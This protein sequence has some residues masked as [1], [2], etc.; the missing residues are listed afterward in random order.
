M[1]I[2]IENSKEFFETIA[3]VILEYYIEEYKYFTSPEYF[4][5]IST[6]EELKEVLLLYEVIIIYIMVDWRDFI[7][8]ALECKWEREHGLG[9]R[10]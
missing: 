6:I 8:I 2:N 9:I 10:I 7:G 5:K 4:P 1:E 3:N